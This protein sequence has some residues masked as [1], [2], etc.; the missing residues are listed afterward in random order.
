M[1]AATFNL[2]AAGI[3][4]ALEC[5]RANVKRHWPAIQAAC[6]E[7]GLTDRACVIAI[8]GTIG[9]E[10]ASFEPINEEGGTRYFTKLY[11]GRGDL[12][13]TQPGDGVRY[14]GRGFLQLTGRANYRAYG[15]KLGLPLEKNPDLALDPDAAARILACYFDE[16]GISEDARRADWETVRRKVNGG[17]N[18]WGR[19]RSLIAR[20]EQ[21]TENK[22]GG[23]GEGAI[24][25]DVLKLKQ[26]LKACGKTHP[27]P[28]PIKRSPLFGPATK[29]AVKAFQR[30]HGIQPTGKVG[31]RTWQALEAAARAK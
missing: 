15:R 7:Y 27:L 23:L 2:T 19:F 11:E 18:G 1:D 21:A 28:V 22:S 5:P 3:A 17:L 10:V 25:P 30:A 13:N 12:G 29:E 20:L 26:L 6:L 24:G 4:G 16:R 31:P 14:H 8:L 9:T